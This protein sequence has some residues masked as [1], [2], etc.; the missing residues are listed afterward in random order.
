VCEKFSER[1]I[2]HP[3]SKLRSTV[4]L[5]MVNHKGQ[6]KKVCAM[7]ILSRQ[8]RSRRTDLPCRSALAHPS[9]ICGTAR[10]ETLDALSNPNLPRKCCIF[11]RNQL[12]SRISRVPIG[13]CTREKHLFFQ[14]HR[15]AKNTLKLHLLFWLRGAPARSARSEKP[16]PRFSPHH[17]KPPLRFFIERR[18][19]VSA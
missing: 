4:V 14:A 17:A 9:P 7:N 6:T 5:S 2:S 3:R 13:L 1:R 12:I 8:R 19:V 10:S 18:T 11:P 16:R 15:S